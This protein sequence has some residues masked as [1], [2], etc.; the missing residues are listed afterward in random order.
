LIPKRPLTLGE[1][2]ALSPGFAEALR[3]AGAQPRVVDGAH[4]GAKLS[5][6]WRGSTPILT[7]GDDIWWPG[8]PADMAKPGFEEVMAILQ[9]EL[10]HV[11]EYAQGRLTAAAYLTGP[12]NWTYAYKL[13]P[14]SRWSDFGAEQRASIV[15]ELWRLERGGDPTKLAAHRR[16]VPWA[17]A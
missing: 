4:P 15:E 2:S 6:L 8:A 14:A 3:D 17:K 1:W 16:L 11:L 5:A 13:S 10:Q 7:R 12:H 9:H